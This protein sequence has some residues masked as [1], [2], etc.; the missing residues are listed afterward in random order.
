MEIKEI[1][2]DIPEGYEIDKEN[3][4]F[5]CIKFKPIKVKRYITYKDCCK[6]IFPND[7]GYYITDTGQVS[8][9]SDISDTPFREWSNNSN[10]ATTKY[11]LQRLLALNQLMNI[12]RYYNNCKYVKKGYMIVYNK[13]QEYEVMEVSDSYY[14]FTTMNPIFEKHEYAQAV[15]NNPNFRNILNTLCR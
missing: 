14:K 10:N 1:K 3:S 11:Q 15:I 12:A 4:T 7:K 6:K 8:G 13:E 9:L 2:I 5:E